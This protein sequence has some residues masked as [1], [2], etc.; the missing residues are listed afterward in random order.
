MKTYFALCLILALAQPNEAPSN[1]KHNLKGVVLE[2]KYFDRVYKVLTANRINTQTSIEQNPTSMRFLAFDINDL[3]KVKSLMIKLKKQKKVN[4]YY[5]M[6][7]DELEKRFFP[8]ITAIDS[9]K[10]RREAEMLQM[11]IQQQKNS[12]F[13]SF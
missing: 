4:D 10:V 2:S 8:P 7:Y 11:K 12:I 6:T 5:F 3:T 13:F 9:M 1:G